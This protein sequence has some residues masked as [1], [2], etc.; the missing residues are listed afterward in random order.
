MDA[1]C[2]NGAQKLLE[3]G[4]V[5]IQT[6]VQCMG[7]SQPH[8]VRISAFKAAQILMVTITSCQEMLC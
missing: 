5:L 4:E 3:N 2:A 8:S 1:L 7:K 6:V